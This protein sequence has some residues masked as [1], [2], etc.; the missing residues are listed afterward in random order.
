LP[1][2]IPFIDLD[3]EKLVEEAIA[4]GCKSIA[5]TYTEPAVFFEYVMDTAKLAKKKGLKN[6][7]VTNGFINPEPL[8]E[9]CEVIDAANVDL[10]SFSDEFYKKYTGAWLNPVL[11]NLKILKEEG[12]WVEITNLIIP[13]LNDDMR[14]I[15]KMCSWIKENL[16][17]ETPVHFSRFFPNYLM[18]DIAP[19]TEEKLVEAY[20]IAE[21]VGLKYVYIGNI[22]TKGGESTKCPRC[23]KIV[24]DRLGFEIRKNNLKNKKCSTCKTKI[25]GVW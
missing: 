6:I 2:D 15:R 23:R 8:R 9:L 16:G 18:Q 20:D 10:K 17:E 3:P 1:E 12:V 13:G 7:I 19:T 22:M 11:E 25:A 21:D 4:N 14:E 24:V 5:Y